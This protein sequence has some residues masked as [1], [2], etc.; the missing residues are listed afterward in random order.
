[1]NNK[2]LLTAALATAFSTVVFA[3]EKTN[4]I[5]PSVDALL[6]CQQKGNSEECQ[7][8]A[9]YSAEVARI[10]DETGRTELTDEERAHIAALNSAIIQKMTQDHEMNIRETDDQDAAQ[11]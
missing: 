10:L 8:F 1:M 4:L 7:N 5:T 9:A 6:Y 3:Q 2:M 11:E